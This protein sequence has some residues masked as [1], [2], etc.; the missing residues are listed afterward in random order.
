VRSKNSWRSSLLISG[1]DLFVSNKD[2]LPSI[3]GAAATPHVNAF[4]LGRMRIVRTYTE[5][6][7]NKSHR[8]LVFETLVQATSCPQMC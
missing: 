7:M 6:T 4:H 1:Q 3:G 5:K 2:L 8:G